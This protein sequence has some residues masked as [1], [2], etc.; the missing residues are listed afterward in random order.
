VASFNRSTGVFILAWLALA[1]PS[2]AQQSAAPAPRVTPAPVRRIQFGI[3][4]R[5][6]N[7]NWNNVFD[8]N[9]GINDQRRQMRYRTMFW[10]TVPLGGSADFVAG[11]NSETTH[12]QCPGALPASCASRFDEFVFDRFYFD[13]RKLP[14]NG[15]ALRIGRQNLQLGEGFLFLEGDPGDGSKSIYVNAVDLS[16]SWKKSRLD[17]IGIFDPKTDRWLPKIHEYQVGGVNHKPLNDWDDQAVGLYYTD[18]RHTK[19]NFESYYFYKKEVNDHKAYLAAVLQPDRYIHTAGGRVVQT[20][21]PTV[22]LTGEWAQQW[23]AQ[24]DGRDIAAWGGYAYATK[25]FNAKWRPYI[26]GGYWAMSGADPAS[27]TVNAN[28]DPIFARWPKFSELYLYSQLK[29]YGIGMNTNLNQVQAEVGFSPAKPIN[30]RVT[31]FH[32]GA[33]HPFPG[34]PAIFGSGLTRGELLVTRIDYVINKYWSGH[35]TIEHVTPGDFYG[36][37]RKPSYFLQFEVSYRFLFSAPAPRF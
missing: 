16:Y 13:F 26:V 2:A 37:N 5:T 22:S 27:T 21:T 7:E 32:M 17:L 10:A 24:H 29:E 6:R 28:F 1:A 8:F 34:S 35:S 14:V 3:D 15:L 18:K 30:W 12:K 9:G 33:Y 25:R 31:Y 19:T 20:V 36:P 23:G 4:Q 11:L